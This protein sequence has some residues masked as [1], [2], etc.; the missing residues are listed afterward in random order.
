M[1][2]YLVESDPEQCPGAL[3]GVFSTREDAEAYI[4][5]QP[6]ANHPE[7]CMVICEVAVTPAGCAVPTGEGFTPVNH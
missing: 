6:R 5:S 1:K 2:V 7:N 4:Q 3:F